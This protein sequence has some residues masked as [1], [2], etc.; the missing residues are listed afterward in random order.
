MKLRVTQKSVKQAYPRI[1]SAG[2]CTLQTLLWYEQPRA[3][4][5]GIYG[6][7]ADIYVVDGVAIAT[8][9]RP[10][11]HGVS[12]ELRQKYENVAREVRAQ[13]LTYEETKEQLH[14]LAVEFVRDAVKE[15]K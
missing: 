6:W 11:G 9:Y 8:G 4:T 5:T 10:F 12:Y 3:Y 14:A 15:V 2:Y 13:R 1:I 7:N